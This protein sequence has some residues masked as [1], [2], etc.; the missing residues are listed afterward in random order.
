MK[1]SIQRLAQNYSYEWNIVLFIEVRERIP[2][3]GHFFYLSRLANEEELAQ[4]KLRSDELEK[5]N[6]ELSSTLTKKEAELEARAQEK[7]DLESNLERTKEKLELEL[8][9]A[10]EARQRLGEIG[11]FFKNGRKRERGKVID[12]YFF[13][14]QASSNLT[15]PT[16]TPP[17]PPPR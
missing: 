1:K 9:R 13:L 5:E 2:N 12:C 3:C 11:F 10:N 17:P 4:I 14:Y 8:A 7:E 16:L 15:S 6:T